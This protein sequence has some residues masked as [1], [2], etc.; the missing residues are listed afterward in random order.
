MAFR[1]IYL[2][3]TGSRKHNGR[4]PE[5]LS[6]KSRLD[7]VNIDTMESVF[8][9]IE[10][11]DSEKLVR[12][13]I[14][15]DG[16][17]YYIKDEILSWGSQHGM[18]FVF[19]SEVDPLWIKYLSV[20]RALSRQVEEFK[21]L[22]KELGFTGDDV[23]SGQYD[24]FVARTISAPVEHQ[25][26]DYRIDEF[27]AA[28]VSDAWYKD[29][30]AAFKAEHLKMISC[31]KQKIRNQVGEI[32]SLRNDKVRLQ[33]QEAKDIDLVKRLTQE[34]EALKASEGS[35]AK[36]NKPMK[37]PDYGVVD[38]IGEDSVRVKK[39]KNFER[40]ISKEELLSQV[41][42]S[43][44]KAVSGIYFLLNDRNNIVYIGQS[45]NVYSRL[46]NTVLI[47]RRT[48]IFQ[49]FSLSPCQ[50]RSFLRLRLCISRHT[51][52]F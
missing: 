1:D 10:N 31:L 12:R 45:I 46:R 28:A 41:T 18:D 19:R 47:R 36:P 11:S 29:E 27:I 6:V 8:S 5:I 26:N 51:T 39:I 49:K 48:S 17:Q 15:T 52:R 38:M 14:T 35:A 40:V 7:I 34:I 3:K 2:R 22:E 32:R 13:Y 21:S 23:I 44:L 16:C 33:K 9:I 25:F 37:H 50:S 42:P 4:V 30:L 43:R 20:H 24:R